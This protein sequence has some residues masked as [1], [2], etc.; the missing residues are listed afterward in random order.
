LRRREG[1]LDDLSKIKH[2]FGIPFVYV[3]TKDRLR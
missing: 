2:K 1:V 3:E